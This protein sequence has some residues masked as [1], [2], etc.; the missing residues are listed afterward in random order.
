MNV[1]RKKLT[2]IIKQQPVLLASWI[3]AILSMFAVAP[4]KKYMDYIDWRSLGILW[5]LMV[6]MQMF[7]ELGVFSYIGR[8]L[9]QRTKTVGQL[10]FVLVGL[11]FVFGMFITND[12]ALITFVPFSILLLE[13]CEKTEKILPVVVL[14]TIAANLGSMLT[15]VGNPQNLYL[16]AI[17]GMSLSEFILWMLP[18]TAASLVLLLLSIIVMRGRKEKIEPRQ[19]RIKRPE[20]SLKLV[21]NTGLF[22]LALFVVARLLNFGLLVAATLLVMLLADRK[23]LRRV[24]YAL[25]FTF[26]GFFVFTGNMGNLP[27]IS[28]HL[29]RI[30]SGNEF[31]AGI[32]V[33]QMISNVPAALLLSG[34]ATDIKELILGVNIGGLGTLI[35]SMASL[36]SYQFYADHKEAKKGRYILRFTWMNLLYLLVL[37]MIHR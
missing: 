15:P 3:L 25:L 18:Y 21:F 19:K 30:V 29:S 4:S 10:V 16:Y 28:E 5:A 12:V 35:A 20:L 24:D 36:I 7:R 22:V 1:M 27:W 8:A 33:S 32:I 2:T 14:Q 11:C 9:L 34:F 6:V 31:A 37:C 23:I 26:V 13:E 17:S